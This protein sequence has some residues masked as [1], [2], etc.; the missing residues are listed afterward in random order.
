MEIKS[1]EIKGNF[2]I[3]RDIELILRDNLRYNYSTNDGSLF[4]D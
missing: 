2:G 4:T 3:G 1:R